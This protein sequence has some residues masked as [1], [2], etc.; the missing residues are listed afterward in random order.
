[1]GYLLCLAQH[2]DSKREQTLYIVKRVS[3]MLEA[4]GAECEGVSSS[5]GS[6]QIAEF[7]FQ[8]RELHFFHLN[9]LLAFGRQICGL[10]DVGQFGLF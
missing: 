8:L 9:V 3:A 5:E 4:F 7:L 10:R 6:L 2:E 1:M